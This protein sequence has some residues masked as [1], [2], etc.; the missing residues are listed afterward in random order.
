[1]KKILALLLITTLVGCT[2][3]QRDVEFIVDL[4]TTG[5]AGFSESFSEATVTGTGLIIVSNVVSP[6]PCYILDNAELVFVDDN[7]ITIYFSLSE[8]PGPC[9][10]CTGSQSIIYHIDGEGLN[11]SGIYCDVITTFDDTED[12]HSF[13]S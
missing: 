12:K 8:N 6:N 9:P 10:S 13:T 11:Q 5:C 3:K 2:G 7:N 1:M 4:H